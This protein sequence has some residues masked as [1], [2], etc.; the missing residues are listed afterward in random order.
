M[1]IDIYIYINTYV[2]AVE[3]GDNDLLGKVGT[4]C[5]SETRSIATETTPH[6]LCSIVVGDRSR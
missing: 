4:P 3:P 5:A 1:G 6:A 2:P